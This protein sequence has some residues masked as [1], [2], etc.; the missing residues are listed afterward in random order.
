[1]YVRANGRAVGVPYLQIMDSREPL[2]PY[3]LLTGEGQRRSVRIDEL[4]KGRWFGPEDVDAILLPDTTARKLG[5]RVGDRVEL[6]TASLEVIGIWEAERSVRQPDGT[7]VKVP[8]LLDRLTDL[9]GLPILPI[10]SASAR[11][12]EPLR[13]LHCASTQ[14]V[15]LP[16]RFHEVH[17]MLPSAVL[18]LIVIPHDASR[19]GA[20]ADRLSNEIRNV[21]VFRHYVDPQT[22]Q[23]RVEMISMRLATQISGSGMMW[24]MLGIAVLMIMA[25]M[26]GTVYER[27]REINIY[28]SVGLAPGHVAGMFLIESLVYAGLASV[29]GYFI[30]IVT[31]RLLSRWHWLPPDFYPNYLGVYVLIATLVAVGAMLLSSI[32]PITVAART[33]NPSLER[34]WQIETEPE[35]DSWRI[36]LPFI[37]TSV[38]ELDG[39]MTYAW[40]FLV[41]HQ[42][43]R[44]G[45]FVCQTPP[46][47]GRR[48]GWHSTEMEVWLA[49]FERN[50][51]E[52][53]VLRAEAVQP[54]R[55]QFV[56]DLTRLSGPEYLWRKGTRVFVDALR[57]HLLNW[58]AMSGEQWDAF[59]VRSAELF[60]AGARA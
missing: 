11:T 42:G 47:A 1:M 13:P 32:Y 12:A 56:L 39:I 46:Q 22:G 57:K 53:A 9:D 31:L 58:R 3:S 2:V 51:T 44:S 19:I 16:R 29:L 14:M 17:R 50:V 54:D 4:V 60:G 49:P 40:D 38:R 23:D 27:I 5:V 37:A 20:L 52:L 24:L 41:I 10:D 55:W 45:R 36:V 35:G 25:I 30:G 15:I 28:S 33:V 59:A 8:G 34:S 6:M 43:E 18:S 26:T 21:D 48:G 7:E